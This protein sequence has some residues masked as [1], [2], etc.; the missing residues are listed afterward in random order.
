MTDD[1]QIDAG[2]RQMLSVVCTR[3]EDRNEALRLVLQSL[4]RVLDDERVLLTMGNSLAEELLARTP[5]PT[6]SAH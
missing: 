3:T 1:E 4:V 5:P 6:D 2:M